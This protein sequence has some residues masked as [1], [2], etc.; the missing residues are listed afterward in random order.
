[1]LDKVTNFACKF[2]QTSCKATFREPKAFKHHILRHVWAPRCN[3]LLDTP[4]AID[5]Y[6]KFLNPAMYIEH[7]D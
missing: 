5:C 4:D 2:K 3:E 6:D 1:M 7:V